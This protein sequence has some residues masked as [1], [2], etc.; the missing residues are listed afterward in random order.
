MN[1]MDWGMHNRFSRIVKPK[2][3]HC[4]MLAVDHGYFGNIPGQLK[5]FGDLNP[6]FQYAD[7]LMILNLRAT[8]F[9][10]PRPKD[11]GGTS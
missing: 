1:F 5:C 9:N 6:L 8:H 10:I 3:G 7:A 2:S 4:V 11:I